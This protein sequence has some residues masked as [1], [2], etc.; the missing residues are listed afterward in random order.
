MTSFLVEKIVSPSHVSFPP[1]SQSSA[2]PAEH[3]HSVI[4]S[5]IPILVLPLL[6]VAGP[7]IVVVDMLYLLLLCLLLWDVLLLDH[8]SR[9]IIPSSLAL[10]PR[11]HL[12]ITIIVSSSSLKISGT[13]FCG[14]FLLPF[15]PDCRVVM[16]F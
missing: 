7:G 6:I 11:P 15:A 12:P 10:A 4:H 14:V 9:L 3:H 16:L 2:S 1:L 8:L 5:D 13:S